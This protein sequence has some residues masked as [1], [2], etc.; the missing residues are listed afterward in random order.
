M[1]KIYKN[2]QTSNNTNNTIKAN[3]EKKKINFLLN[4]IPNRNCE[5]LKFIGNVK[6]G[7]CGG[8]R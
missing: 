7:T 1:F 4:N 3:K 2:N 6:C 8:A 5:S